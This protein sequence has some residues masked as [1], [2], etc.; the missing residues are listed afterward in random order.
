MKLLH[1]I[2]SRL[3]I[4]FFALTVTLGSVG[5]WGYRRSLTVVSKY[6]QTVIRRLTLER[7]SGNLRN[8]ALAER[9]ALEQY[10]L[11][12]RLDARRAFLRGKQEM[13]LAIL[14][15]R[16]NGSD[17]W[18][19]VDSLIQI[20]RDFIATAEDMFNS[21]DRMFQPDGRDTFSALQLVH[22]TSMGRLETLAIRMDEALDTV[23][24]SAESMQG[25]LQSSADATAHQEFLVQLFAMIAGFLISIGIWWFGERTIARPLC[26][27]AG[28]VADIQGS[29]LD[30]RVE[31]Q[32]APEIRYLQVR[33]NELVYRLQKSI[34]H[35]TAR[36]MELIVQHGSV[37]PVT[38]VREILV[39]IEEPLSTASSG[40]A[41][42]LK[43][44]DAHAA[45]KLYL[46]VK[47]LNRARASLRLIVGSKEG[48]NKL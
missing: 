35:H 34:D 3:A 14:A 45:S 24:A 13:E 32:G 8:A 26:R 30:G 10:H 38:I 12:N 21:Y 25:Q 15:L 19:T 5:F 6:Q 20:E 1:G 17:A 9:L 41:D 46:A 37:E 47:S 43:G 16:Q 4:M 18:A 42:Y 29:R 31:I 36:Q 22:R 23:N 2:S 44:A 11:E 28:E 39:S 7:A 40:I 33:F 27:F 48:V